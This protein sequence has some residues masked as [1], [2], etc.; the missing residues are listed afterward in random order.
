MTADA[1]GN[2]ATTPIPVA[3]LFPSFGAASGLAPAA[4]ATPGCVAGGGANSLECGAG[5]V[6]S[7]ANATALGANAS[8]AQANTVAL[9]QGVTTSRAGQVAIGGAT[10]T[11]TL[12]GVGSDASRAAQT[13]PL[14]TLTTDASGNI[15]GDGGALFNQFQGVQNDVDENREGVALAL[16]VDTPDFVAGE[17]FGMRMNFGT[18]EGETALGFSAAGVVA[19]NVFGNNGRVS[20][21]AGLGYGVGEGTFG[22]RAGLQLTW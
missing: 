15:A 3:A 19:E 16:A 20:I 18:F 5:S 2:L 12:A 4:A 6:A 22:A 10:N 14:Q 17:K 9:G 7:G 11:Y 13:G 1:N 21:D 8:A